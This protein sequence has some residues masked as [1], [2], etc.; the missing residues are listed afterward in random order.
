MNAREIS[1]AHQSGSDII[2]FG[3]SNEH[4][5][6]V[7]DLTSSGC[8]PPNKETN[9]KVMFKTR[10]NNAHKKEM[11]IRESK[12][13]SAT[14][15]FKVANSDRG[16]KT[17]QVTL[18]TAPSCDCPDFRKNKT[19]VVCSHILFV[20]L[21]A[22]DEKGLEDALKTRYISQADITRI[23]GKQIK[24]EYLQIKKKRSR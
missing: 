21:I 15:T 23:T 7:L 3:A 14:R 16:R 2:E 4:E 10:F 18:A 20:V 11:K 13:S 5:D 24:D 19:K 17:Y 22:L 9:V 6:P 1:A 8:K 12:S